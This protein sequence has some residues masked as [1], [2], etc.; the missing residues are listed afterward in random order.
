MPTPINIIVK[1][2]FLAVAMVLLLVLAILYVKSAIQSYYWRRYL[3]KPW[4]R[5]RAPQVRHGAAWSWPED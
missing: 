4:W 1:Q 2:P 3:D 5:R